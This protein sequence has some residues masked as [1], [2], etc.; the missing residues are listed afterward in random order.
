MKENNIMK[1]TKCTGSFLEG[2]ATASTFCVIIKFIFYSSFL[3]PYLVQRFSIRNI[4]ALIEV[5]IT[6]KR[7]EVCWPV[8]GGWEEDWAPV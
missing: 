7:R 8:G 2:D 1:F 5:N 3:F 6:M 4:L